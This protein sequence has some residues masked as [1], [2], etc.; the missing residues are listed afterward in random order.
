MK[1]I[2]PSKISWWLVVLIS[3]VVIFSAHTLYTQEA[4]YLEYLPLLAVAIFVFYAFSS[5][6]YTIEDNILTVKSTFL[7]NRKIDILTITQISES[8][9][10]L[11][12]PA[13]SL[14]R[15]KIVYDNGK[16]TLISPKDKEVFLQHVKTIQPKIIVKRK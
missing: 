1:T 10:P 3:I 4:N 15:L 12:A 13:A 16:W 5:T 9:N 7:I 8:N 6:N 14:D 2:Y 11:S